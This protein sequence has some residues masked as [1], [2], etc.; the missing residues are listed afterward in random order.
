MVERAAIVVV[1]LVLMLLAGYVVRLRIRRRFEA[2]A[3]TAL[4]AE[5]GSRLDPSTPGIVYFYGPHCSTCRRQA[6]ILEEL[7]AAHAI[8][9]LRVD[10]SSDTH[11]ADELGVMTVP[12]TV[13]VDRSQR[14]RSINLGFRSAETLRE[15]V[16]S[17]STE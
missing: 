4:P 12:A 13:V 8:P 10:A 16:L 7:G 14:V 9:I 5:I 3:L 11:L 1:V 2:L 6:G 15:Q 17:L